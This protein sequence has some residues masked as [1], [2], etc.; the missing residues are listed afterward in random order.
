M[1]NLEVESALCMQSVVVFIN[2]H[3]GKQDESAEI[4]RIAWRIFLVNDS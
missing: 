4:E 2:I 3:S 1:A